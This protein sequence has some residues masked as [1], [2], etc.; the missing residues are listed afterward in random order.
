MHEEAVCLGCGLVVGG[1]GEARCT[2]PPPSIAPAPLSGVPSSTATTPYRAP[3]TAASCPRCQGR[4]LEEALDDALVLS[5]SAC[6][7]VFLTRA[8]IDRL[9]Q[10]G[11]GALRLAFPRR[12]R[13]PE[14]TVVRYLS[15]PL[16][17][18][19]M[20]RVNF[21]RTANV[22][23]DVCKEDGMWFDAG[24]VHAVIDFVEKGGLE[25]ARLRTQQDRAQENEKLRAEWRTLHDESVRAMRIVR[26]DAQL[27]PGE[28]ELVSTFFD[29]LKG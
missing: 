23:V 1:R 25:R 5:C 20:N 12:P 6:G 19:R 18:A 29:W 26:N 8:V 15:C 14:P 22:I 11:S 27:S 17:A 13:A 10:P 16:C 7:G 2:C 4:M 28:R 3:P 9:D 24:E 21:A